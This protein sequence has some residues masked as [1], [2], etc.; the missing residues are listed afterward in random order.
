MS[1]GEMITI[2]IATLTLIVTTVAFCYTIKQYHQKK[3]EDFVNMVFE[4]L[5]DV[6]YYVYDIANNKNPSTKEYLCVDRI[7]EAEENLTVGF[8]YL[9]EY[10]RSNNLKLMKITMDIN[11]KKEFR[12]ISF[13][14]QF[15]R[16]N[17]K[18]HDFRESIVGKPKTA[19]INDKLDK[20][21]N[22]FR[23][24]LHFPIK[25]AIKYLNKRKFDE[26][27]ILNRENSFKEDLEKLKKFCEEN[28][29]L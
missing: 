8:T 24:F 18:F 16:L 19:E 1:C 27:T 3:K 20:Y 10:A 7:R 22:A 11:P 5:K 15:Y 25:H 29:L 23:D 28:K 9:Y 2:I 26:K 14:Y 12:D 13:G 4:Q 17:G 21:C 6:A